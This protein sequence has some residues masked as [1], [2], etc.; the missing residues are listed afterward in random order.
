MGIR[1]AERIMT[2]RSNKRNVHDKT[3][4]LNFISDVVTKLPEDHPN[5][6]HLPFAILQS[7]D[8]WIFMS[9]EKPE[10]DLNLSDVEKY[11]LRQIELV[12]ILDQID[13]LDQPHTIYAVGNIMNNRTNL[14]WM[15]RTR[16]ALASGRYIPEEMPEVPASLTGVLVNMIYADDSETV[17]LHGHNEETIGIKIMA[18]THNLDS[19]VDVI[20]IDRVKTRDFDRAEM[21]DVSE[22]LGGVIDIPNGW[23]DV[24]GQD[25]NNLTNLFKRYDS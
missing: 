1:S 12:S 20:E 15:S 8:E 24:V 4:I 19:E 10:V 17:S 5:G 13:S 25:V 7:N 21:M 3:S 11:I 14:S 18:S 2:N 22:S 6:G 23:E 9:P 16:N